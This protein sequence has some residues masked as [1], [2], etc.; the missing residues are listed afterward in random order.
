VS[1]GGLEPPYRCDFPG[2]GKSCNKSNTTGTDAPGYSAACSL[3]GP[4]PG[5]HVT[6]RQARASASPVAVPS[7]SGSWATRADRAPFRDE[8]GD[9]RVRRRYAGQ[10]FVIQPV[11]R[12]AGCL[13]ACVTLGRFRSCR[14]ADVVFSDSYAFACR[15]PAVAS[16]IGSLR[17][18]RP[19]ARP[20][21][22]EHRVAA[23]E[24]AAHW[25]PIM[26]FCVP[27][28]QDGTAAAETAA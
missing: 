6:V 28:Q 7:I 24:A 10:H 17:S 23:M 9:V 3:S 26:R 15:P 18:P 21:D 19:E 8:L 13:G 11:A 1:E 27:R 12:R 16:V 20:A 25:I 2:S 22:T 14:I 4:V 5:L